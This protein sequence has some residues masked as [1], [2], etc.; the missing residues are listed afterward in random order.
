[1][2][3]ESKLAI[4]LLCVPTLY[5][6]KSVWSGVY[7]S[8]Q[9][10]R[11]EAVYGTRCAKCHEGADVDGPPLTGDPFLDRWREDTLA[12]LYNFIKEKMPQDNPGKLSPKEYVDVLT[13]VLNANHMPSGN[14]ELT[15]EAIPATLFVGQDGPKPLPANALVKAVGCLTQ[16]T[17]RAWNLAGVG[18]LAR[19][20]SADEATPAELAEATS[21]H[22]GTQ[23][24][25]LRNLAELAPGFSADANQGHRVMVKGVLARRGDAPRI[26]VLSAGSVAGDC[27][28]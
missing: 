28:P 12:S 9:A 18:E 15:A 22:L 16:D 19:V 2:R 21:R 24:F 27:K 11:G 13:Y 6:Q 26:N 3:K 14:Q 10:M 5:A 7:T 23:T 17:N 1:M 20:R 25:Q 4:V 8:G